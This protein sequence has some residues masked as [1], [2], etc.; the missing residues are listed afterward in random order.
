MA[1]QPS[2]AITEDYRLRHLLGSEPG[3][4]SIDA[5]KVLTLELE[6]TKHG[7]RRSQATRPATNV[8]R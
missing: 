3:L 4:R 2:L 7:F 8:L 5:R 6:R 1:M